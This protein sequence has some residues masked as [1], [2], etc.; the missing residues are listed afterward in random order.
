LKNGGDSREANFHEGR[1]K[2]RRVGRP[3]EEDAARGGRGS[4]SPWRSG[5]GKPLKSTDYAGLPT[6][7]ESRAKKF[8]WRSDAGRGQGWRSERAAGAEGGESEGG[9]GVSHGKEAHY[10][11]EGGVSAKKGR[12]KEKTA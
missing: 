11:T 8:A 12:R 9:G 10:K 3:G 1:G 4:R 7:G 6:T 2:P 5:W